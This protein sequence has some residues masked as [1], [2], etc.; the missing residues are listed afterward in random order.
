MLADILWV[1][2]GVLV[3]AFGIGLMV[4][5]LCEDRK[6]EGFSF[7]RA[8]LRYTGLPIV[9]LGVL[10]TLMFL[11]PLVGTWIMEVAGWTF[12]GVIGFVCLG[13]LGAAFTQLGDAG[14][15]RGRSKTRR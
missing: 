15:P 14:R 3:T 12:V 1:V 11:S 2:G 9:V 5:G 7:R 10:F 8:E 13:L 4:V 6:E